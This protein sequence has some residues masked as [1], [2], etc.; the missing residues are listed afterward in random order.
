MKALGWIIL[1]GWTAFFL[2]FL[3]AYVPK[4][5]AYLFNGFPALLLSA[6]GIFALF[7]KIEQR[8]ANKK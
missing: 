8:S 1:F 3:N 5:A 4:G 2:Y 7:D 6:F